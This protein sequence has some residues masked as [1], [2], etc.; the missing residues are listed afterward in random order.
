MDP[1]VPM[2]P[3]VQ[4]E[5]LAPWVLLGCQE[6]GVALDPAVHLVCVAHLATLANQVQWVPWVSMDHLA[7]QDHQE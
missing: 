2:A 3:L 6:R 5:D 4:W 1:R 7:I